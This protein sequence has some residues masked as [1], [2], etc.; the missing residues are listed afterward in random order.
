MDLTRL[1]L[2]H[3][4][5]RDPDEEVKLELIEK[6]AYLTID[7]FNGKNLQYLD[8]L[9]QAGVKNLPFANE[10]NFSAGGEH[11]RY[12]HRGW[13]WINY[14]TNVRGYNFQQIW[15]KRKTILLFTL[16]RVFEFKRNEMIKRDSLAALIYYTH[17]LGDHW[18]DQKGSYMDRIPITP[19]PDY[20]FNRSG[21]N[22]NNPTVYT[23]L[24]Y[25][26]P[27][28]F[29]E[30]LNSNEFRMLF[31]FLQRH[32]SKEFP[33]G[34]SITDEEYAELQI[35]ARQTLDTLSTYIP[36]LLQ[37]EQFFKRAFP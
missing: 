35:F 21:P 37:N 30:Q 14:P 13:D 7:Q 4:F 23:E 24:L 15:E 12:T 28:L 16:D 27:R 20:R 5:A 22:S 11:Q 8:E 19:R 25:H 34:T 9:I 10:I 32:K 1:M 31:F 6:A 26:I 29:R 17:I 36:R 18:G 2:G 3:P 33:T